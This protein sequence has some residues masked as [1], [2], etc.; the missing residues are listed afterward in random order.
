MRAVRHTI[1]EPGD[2]VEGNPIRIEPAIEVGNIFKLGT[3][4]SEPLGASFLDEDGRQQFVC[5]GSYGLGPARI[6]AAAVEQ[7]ADERGISWPAAI[8]PFDVHLVAVGKAATPERELAESVYT[9]LADTGL[10]VIFDDREIAPG[11]KFADADLLGCP[12]R[13]TVGKRSLESGLVEV[14]RRRGQESLPGLPLEGLA[15][16]VSALWLTAP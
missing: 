10:D 7:F 2:L 14:V 5:M 11:Q 6:V 9:M 1:V 15:D 16:A 4:Y 12:L 13:L 3:R 8:A